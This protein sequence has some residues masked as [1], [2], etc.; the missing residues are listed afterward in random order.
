MYETWARS[1]EPNFKR[2]SN[3]WKHPGSPRPNE[4]APYTMSVKIMSIM[5]Y[6]IDVVI[7]HHAVP[8]RQTVNSA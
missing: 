3:E 4:S 1:Y 5:A 7:L 8:P 6:D 2:Q